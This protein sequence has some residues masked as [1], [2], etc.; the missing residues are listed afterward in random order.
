MGVRSLAYWV[1][2]QYR[3]GVHPIE[4][5][6]YVARAGGVDQGSLTRE[7]A[8]ALASLGG[9]PAELVMS[10][11]RML[12]RH[13]TAGALWAMSAR[14]LLAADPMSAAWEIAREL[15]DDPTGGTL[16]AALPEDAVITLLG[17]PDVAADALHRRGDIEVRVLDAY[18]EGG[19]LARRL[20]QGGTAVVEVP[21]TGLGAACAGADVVVIEAAAAGPTGLV[22]AGGSL[23]AAAVGA[24]AGAQVWAAIPRGRS[25]PGQLFE[26]V[27]AQ[28]D[29]DAPW[30]Q[31]EEFVPLELVG[32]WVTPSGLRPPSQ[33]LEPDCEVAHELLRFG[34]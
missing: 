13:P 10:C 33:G 32:T 15:E 11:R 9:D 27:K 14:V 3:Q 20:Q 6:R 31:E 21:L 22:A 28:L 16:A 7:A 18:G 5:L 34:Y 26:A 8:D 4:R 17:W 24:T 25:L 23:A 29:M 30:E 1:H 2:G 19:G 12:A